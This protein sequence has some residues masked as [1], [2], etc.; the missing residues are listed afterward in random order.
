VDVGEH[1]EEGYTD[2]EG[3]ILVLATPQGL[4]SATT[5]YPIPASESAS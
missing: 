4:V 5:T 2:G 1:G 3:A